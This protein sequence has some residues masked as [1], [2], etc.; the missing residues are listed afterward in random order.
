VRRK[1]GTLLAIEVALLQAAVDFAGSGDPDFYG[2]SVARAIS[3]REGARQL[4]SHGTL[5]K[6]LDRLRKSG[7]LESRW[8]DPSIGAAE[9][10]P[11]RRLYHITAEGQRAL[12]VAAAAMP[13]TLRGSPQPS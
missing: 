12:L 3:E 8:E 2:Y 7:F 13:S 11:R 10:R 4:T 6:A 1:P 5:Y 9:E